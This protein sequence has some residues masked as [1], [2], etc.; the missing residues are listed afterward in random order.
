MSS[1]PSFSIVNRARLYFEQPCL[2]TCLPSMP[3]TYTHGTRSKKRKFEEES[4]EYAKPTFFTKEKREEIKKWVEQILL[5][6]L[7]NDK[8]I[9]QA[10]CGNCIS[11]IYNSQWPMKSMYPNDISSI[12]EYIDQVVLPL[13]R[14]QLEIDLKYKKY[15]W[16][17]DLYLNAQQKTFAFHPYL[18]TCFRHRDSVDR[19]EA[20]MS[21]FYAIFP[22]LQ[23]V[24]CVEEHLEK[25]F[26]KWSK[27]YRALVQ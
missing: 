17:P 21:L 13:T 14:L 7:T 4:K 20:W 8:H 3:R 12:D 9:M 23:P 11:H 19:K 2:N 1:D 6:I 10:G 15:K 27:E 16:K 18:G 5:K 24:C 25:V 22:T 26:Q